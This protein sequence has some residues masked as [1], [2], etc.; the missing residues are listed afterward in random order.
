MGYGDHNI[1]FHLT[2]HG[3]SPIH[4]VGLFGVPQNCREGAG[5]AE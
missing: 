1:S 3:D 4:G 2:M 5:D